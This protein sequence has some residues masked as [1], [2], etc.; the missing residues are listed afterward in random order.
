M[1]HLLLG[2]KLFAIAVLFVEM[3]VPAAMRDHMIKVWLFKLELIYC[4]LTSQGL[5]ITL[6]AELTLL[7]QAALGRVVFDC[8]HD[9][10]L[11]SGLW[12]IASN[13][14]WCQMWLTRWKYAQHLGD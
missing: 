12:S 8:G 3:S 6:M 14:W 5:S 11:I 13:G 9:G 4:V 2:A 10:V 7:F 1:S